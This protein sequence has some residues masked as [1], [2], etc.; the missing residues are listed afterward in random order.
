M[1]APLWPQAVQRA[2]WLAPLT[3]SGREQF[4]LN[5]R[6]HPRGSKGLEG[7]PRFPFVDQTGTQLAH[8]YTFGEI[9]YERK[10][11]FDRV[12]E[13]GDWTGNP[14]TVPAAF[15][16]TPVPL[17]GYG[18]SA[19]PEVA[20]CDKIFTQMLRQLDQAW[21]SG[22]ENALGDAIDSMTSLKSKAIALLMRQVPSPDPGDGVYGPQFRK[23]TA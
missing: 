15:K 19:P 8:F 6:L 11:V 13:T 18:A 17:D 7:A 2:Q 21:A 14:V 3:T 12:K 4:S 9:Y 1:V 22:D 10:Y 23:A 5:S 20:E 16:M